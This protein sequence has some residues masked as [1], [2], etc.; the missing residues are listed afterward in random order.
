MRGLAMALLA[1]AA[2][3]A[4]ADDFET[5]IVDEK[6]L[7]VFYQA[8]KA[9]LNFP[10]GY[11]GGDPAEW[12]ERAMAAAAPLMLPYEAEAPFAPEVIDEED[13]GSYTARRIAFNITD[14]SR[15]SAI[16][17]VPAGEG[18]FPAALMLHDHGARFDIGK[19]KWVSPWYDGTRAASAEEWAGKYF[20]GRYPGEELAKRGYVVLATDALGWGDREGNGYEAQ[21]ALAANLFNLGSSL[22]GLMALEDMRAAEFLAGL[23]ETD[24]DRVAAV[25]FSMGAFR[26]WQVAALSPHVAAAVANC[27]MA[28]L[29]GL[30][31]PGNNQLKG[32]SAWYML[33]PGLPQLM[34]YPDVAALA[35]PKP[36]LV[37][38]GAEDPL[39]PQ[40]SVEAAFGQ[41][42]AVWDAYGADAALTTRVWEGKGHTFTA[43]MQDAAFDWLDAALE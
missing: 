2:T 25:G 31:V 20:S 6:N 13:R 38:A 26:A 10:L 7:P 33:H 39:F 40:A 14:E 5:E 35:A 28:T 11:D 16:L 27:W 34:D 42:H 22:A 8:L 41:M 17:L 24:P 9:R 21:Q 29:D 15:V 19:E 37:H 18:P 36:M 30:M 4:A 43:D 32:Q 23:P 1:G 12:H 3:M